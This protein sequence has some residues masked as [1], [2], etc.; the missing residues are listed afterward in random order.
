MSKKGF[1]LVELL[2]VF[3]IL[4]I[5]AAI[6]LVAINPGRKLANARDAER[7]NDI[8]AIS[9]AFHQYLI[10]NNDKLPEGFP[11]AST[12]IGNVSEC[13]NL[14]EVLVPTYLAYVPEDPLTGTSANT[15]YLIN[16]ED[17]G[18]V[19]IRASGE[20]AQEIVVAR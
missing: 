10:E 13:F 4:G 5:F 3:G 7:R 1:S 20:I 18:R 17:D 2:V 9:D 8:V 12:C 16:I 15:Q 19:V 11:S 14:A 6:I